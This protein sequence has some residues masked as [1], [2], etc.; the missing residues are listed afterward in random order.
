MSGYERCCR[1]IIT[2]SIL[3]LPGS[4]LECLPCFGHLSGILDARFASFMI[5]LRSFYPGLMFLKCAISLVDSLPRL[6]V[7]ATKRW[8]SLNRLKLMLV[9]CVRCQ[10]MT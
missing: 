4:V 5:S 8:R 3:I 10:I 9:G 6:R 7:Y 2:I 1:V